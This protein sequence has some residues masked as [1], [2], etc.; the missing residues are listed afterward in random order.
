MK[1]EN[2]LD[3]IFINNIYV[4]SMSPI[5]TLAYLTSTTSSLLFPPMRFQYV[6]FPFFLQLQHCTVYCGSVRRIFE[7]YRNI[8]LVISF[9]NK[10]RTQ[11]IALSFTLS[12]RNAISFWIKHSTKLCQFA[13]ALNNIFNWSRFHQ[14]CIAS[15]WWKKV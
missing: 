4:P 7:L 6:Q 11:E 2:D 1:I 12:H 13:V 3:W 14:E 5:H 9:R 10:I 15:Y 8:D